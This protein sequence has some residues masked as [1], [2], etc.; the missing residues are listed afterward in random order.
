[1]S[2]AP[3]IP[4]EE[5]QFG[6]RFAA[7]LP[8]FLR[9]PIEIDE[10][11]K[12]LESRFQQRE[13]RFIGQIHRTVYASSASPYKELL[14]WAGCEAGDL[15]K[16]V[17]QNG[18]EG[19]LE[20][21]YRQGVYLTVDEFKGRC[22][23]VR[24]SARLTVH[25]HQLQNPALSSHLK[26]R[27]SGSRSPGTS[28]P[29][30]LAYVAGRSVNALLDLT[31]RGGMKWLHAVWGIPGGSALVHLLE[32]SGFGACPVRWFSLVDP[33]SP[34]LHPRYRWSA[35]LL[36]WTSLLAGVPLPRL[37]VASVHDAAQVL[38]WMVAVIRSGE[39]PHLFTYASAAVRICDAAR[40]AGV[41]LPGM[42][43]T[44]TGEPVTRTR[45]DAVRQTGAEATPR[46]GSA[47]SGTIGY[48]C[49]EAEAADEVHLLQDRLALVQAG[50]ELEHQGIPAGALFVTTLDPT[51][52]YVLLNVSL[53]DRAAMGH[54]SCGCP[55]Q[56]YGWTTHLHSIRSYEKLTVG[57]MSF[58][59][60][61]LV[62]IL[63]ETL[64]K[65]FGGGPTD[66]QLLEEENSR[67]LRDYRLLVH[68][69]VGPIDPK[70]VAE[71]F[72]DAIG[73]G[74]G[75]ERIMGTVWRDADS[76]TVERRP[77]LTTRSG[78]ILHVHAQG[79][80]R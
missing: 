63:E 32:F 36:R 16:L 30:D 57:G 41:E 62:R 38:R 11:K 49:L 76:L 20:V 61:D 60:T 48:G 73:P 58:L 66:Y 52:P 79:T 18:V 25:P 26:I 2:P 43:F 77:P 5:L 3:R 1:M 33:G 53:G 50:E 4:L 37:Q 31:A 55:L 34:G 10:A 64:P 27:T 71:T 12:I 67:S 28:V 51:T 29:I 78:K 59:E 80:E 8:S 15:E 19:A 13:K 24:G 72:F 22:P 42:Q 17:N 75:I 7:Q 68:P 47:E 21:L 45:L 74:G 65:R 70:E 56:A 39:T 14:R 69:A 23:I 46:Y 9:R 40:E 54:R 44:V 6:I 35:L